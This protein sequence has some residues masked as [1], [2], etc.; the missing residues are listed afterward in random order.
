MGDAEA[1]LVVIA[2]VFVVGAIL[3]DLETRREREHNPYLDKYPPKVRRR[4]IREKRR[5]DRFRRSQAP[6]P[7]RLPL[8]RRRPPS[9]ETPP[10]KQARAENEPDSES[11]DPPTERRGRP[12]TRY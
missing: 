3:S 5:A 9:D 6:R 10:R 11:E 1:A 2:L 4:L 7:E 8:F 12:P